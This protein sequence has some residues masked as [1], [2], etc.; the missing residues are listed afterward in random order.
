LIESSRERVAGPHADEAEDNG[1][2]DVEPAAE[3]FAIFDK[4]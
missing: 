1:E 4:V 2:Q 3:P